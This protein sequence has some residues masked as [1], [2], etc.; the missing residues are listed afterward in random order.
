MRVTTLTLK[1][2]RGIHDMELTLHRRMNVFIGVNGAGKSSVLDALSVLLSKFTARLR[3]AGSTGRTFSELDIT[4]GE[5]GTQNAISVRFKKDTAYNPAYNW[6]LAKNRKG[7]RKKFSSDLSQGKILAEHIQTLLE[8]NT[9]ARIP[10][11][12]HYMVNRAVLDVPLRIRTRHTFSQVDAHDQALAVAQGGFRM[13]FEWF[14]DREDYENET[15]MDTP[16]HRDRQ[17]EAVR[18]TLTEFTG[19]ASPRVQRKPLRMEM[20][21]EGEVLDIR[22]MSDGEKCLLAM[23][24]DLARRLAMANPVLENPLEGE[25]V[26]LIDE[27]DLHLHPSWQRRMVPKLMEV[28][29]NCQF[30][31]TTHSPQV[32]AHVRPENLFLLEKTD[33]GI[34]CHRP[35]E[36]YGK[37]SDGVL[38]DIMDLPARPEEIEN[39]IRSLFESIA[40]E[41]IDEAKALARELRKDLGSDP[42]ILHAELLIRRKEVTGA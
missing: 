2:F 7:A 11:A 29:P 31:L 42:D 5:T 1:N 4:N 17:L 33:A 15:R 12:V 16:A 39:K 3:H 9:D 23:T 32:I 14:R 18:R 28:F 40:R 20:T 34:V 27:T 26:V 25:G 38:T 8:E 36:S 35:T 24:G 22:Q 13:F 6:R 30:V 41:R 37:S 21:K 10:I 19:Y